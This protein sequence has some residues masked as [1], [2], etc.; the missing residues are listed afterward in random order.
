MSD[1]FTKIVYL[2]A[3]TPKAKGQSI[4]SALQ[5]PP[6]TLVCGLLERQ[7]KNVTLYSQRSLSLS[8]FV[9]RIQR[10]NRSEIAFWL[11]IHFIMY[12]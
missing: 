8:L 6:D 4:V 3:D 7:T 10:C 1:V 11:N 2:W 9:D 12:M 5:F